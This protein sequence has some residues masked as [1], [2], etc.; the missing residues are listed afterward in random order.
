MKLKS[1]SDAD[2]V[3]AK[4][5]AKPQRERSETVKAATEVAALNWLGA[6]RFGNYLVIADEEIKVIFPVAANGETIR[7]ELPRYY[8][9]CQ[10]EGSQTPPVTFKYHRHQ[11]R[12]LF[13]DSRVKGPVGRR[14]VRGEIA[15]MLFGGDVE[16]ADVLMEQLLRCGPWLLD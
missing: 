1:L 11:G 14:Y 6:E 4:A 5:E 3:E 15:R 10:W 13:S 8:L 9:H 7:V 12:W 16:Q 2:L